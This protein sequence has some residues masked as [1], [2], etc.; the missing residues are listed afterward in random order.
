GRAESDLR[1]QLETVSA[2]SKQSEAAHQQAQACSSQLEQELAGMRQAREELTG[3]FGKELQATAES[4]ARI[5]ELEA[6][7]GSKSAELERSKAEL[8]KQAKERGRAE[9]DL[10][11]QLETANAAIKEG[12]VTHKQA[13]ALP[14]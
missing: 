1:Q 9:S 13:D 7:L 8:E 12:E 2:T 14:S 3:K 5:K 4:H 10:R 11:Q 6:H